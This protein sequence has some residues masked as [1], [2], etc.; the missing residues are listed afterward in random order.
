M[1]NFHPLCRDMF[2]LPP[3]P[4]FR[5]K[6]PSTNSNTSDLDS[7]MFDATASPPE[8]PG[9]VENSI[10]YIVL[11]LDN[12]APS[13]SAKVVSPTYKVEGVSTALATTKAGLG[14]VTIDFDKTDALI[15]SANQR[16]FKVRYL[17]RPFL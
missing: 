9:I 14:Y 7:F 16:F 17:F 11:D 4:V 1:I 10:N 6:L 12:P 15:K 8:S 2:T 13:P 5:P 3:K